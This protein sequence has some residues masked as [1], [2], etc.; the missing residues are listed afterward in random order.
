MNTILTRRH[1][2]G[3]LG[4]AVAMPPLAAVSSARE[5]AGKAAR[6]EAARRRRRVI[7]NNDGNDAW[8]TDAPAT[9]DG[10]LSIRMDHIAGCGVDSV[11]YCTAQ[12]SV[13]THDSKVLEVLKTNTGHYAHN[14]MAALLA[15]GT[16][17]LRL[18]VEWCRKNNVEVFWSLRMNDIHDNWWPG[19]R[20]KLKTERPELVMDT[21]KQASRYDMRDPR[22]IWTLYDYGRKEVRDLMVRA[23]AEVLANYD[24]DGIDLDFLRHVCYFNETRFYQPVTPAHRALLTD[25]MRQIRE[26]VLAASARKGRPILLSARVL[27]TMALNQR[28]GLDVEQ[29]INKGYLDFITA[30]GGF[31]PFTSPGKALVDWCHARGVPAYGCITAEGLSQQ[32]PWSGPPV[33]DSQLSERSQESWRGAAANTWALGV[34][35]IMTF[36]LFPDRGGVELSRNVLREINDPK[37]FVAKDKLFCIEHLCDDDYAWMIRSVPREGRLP[38]CISKGSTVTRVLPVA[39]DIASLAGGI[40]RLR[41]RLYLDHLREPDK[42][43]VR[44]NGEKL[45][46]ASDQP[47][48]LA[49]EVAPALMKKGP[50]ELAVTFERGKS[51]S[52]ALTLRSV[53]LS[54]Q[55]AEP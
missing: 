26:R 28:F 33:P 20:A 30:G 31:D 34:D 52:W 36:N 27:Q 9:K 13:F 48:W 8:V 50:N 12:S 43:S 17:P 4:A 22:S 44:L 6:K 38:V 19:L 24:V 1:F 3:C 29:W 2:L 55:Y 23:I 10:F 47:Q 14:R 45:V 40:R 35:G 41:L 42:V 7:F 21:A 49:A 25:M 11:F 51:A 32:G 53:E 37:N 5:S 39:D 16:D 15:Q 54:V 46:T 18:A